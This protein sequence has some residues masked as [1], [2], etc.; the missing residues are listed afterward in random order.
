ML[1]I[2]PTVG[3]DNVFVSTSVA[4]SG[5]ISEINVVPKDH[6]LAEPAKRNTLGAL[7]WVVASLV[8]RGLSEHTI[9]ILTADHKIEQPEKFRATVESAFWAAEELDSLVTIG[10]PPIRP[11]TGFGYLEA[12]META[13]NGPGNAVCY[14]IKRFREKP[15]LPTA[16]EFIADPSFSWNAGMFFF[17]ISSFLEALEQCQP[18]A[19][20]IF[21]E[22]ARAFR[23]D[24]AQR[25]EHTFHK[26]TSI[27]FDFAVMEKASRV[28][29][30]PANFPWDDVGSWDAL[31]RSIEPDANGNVI[32]GPAAVL[33]SS[34]C[35]VFNDSAD[36]KIGVL[37]MHGMLVVNTKHAMF[38]CPKGD[39]QRVKEIAQAVRELAD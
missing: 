35:I 4:L 6:V 15:D 11:D 13:I 24:D 2:V 39:A 5:P 19:F 9:A 26:L 25:A 23:D 31:A 16:L 14:S 8:N 1:R 28:H 27:S 33:E 36:V 10:I 18:E 37:G 38:V 3:A 12:D 34:N 21:T 17:K 20:H 29:M 22:I 32:Q 7:I 30:V